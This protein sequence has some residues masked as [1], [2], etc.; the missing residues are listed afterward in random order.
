[1]QVIQD[2]A[3]VAEEKRRAALGSN[4][5]DALK[6]LLSDRLVFVHSSGTLDDKQ[7]LLQKIS[8]GTIRY[9]DIAFSQLQTQVLLGEQHVLVTGFMRARILVAGAERSVRSRY[10][11]V[12]S[13]EADGCMRLVAHQGTAL[14][15]D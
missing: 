15:L 11:A 6:P 13:V 3:L 10:L 1:M 12:W 14:P 9:L 7:Q 2:Q 4:D 5:V 8:S